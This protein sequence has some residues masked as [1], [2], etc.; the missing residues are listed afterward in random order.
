MA[1]KSMKL[2][3]YRGGVS[4]GASAANLIEDFRIAVSGDENLQS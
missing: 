1:V 4:P 2:I 3:V